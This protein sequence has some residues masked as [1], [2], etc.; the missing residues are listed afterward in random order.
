MQLAF[1]GLGTMGG[2]MAANLLKAGH[3]VTV[4]N[5]TRDKEEPLA[6]KG[7]KRAASPKEAASEAEVVFLCVSDTPDV[8]QVLFGQDGV[9]TGAK[10]GAV[11]ADMSTISPA[12]TRR[13]AAALSEKGIMMVDAPISGGSEGAVNGTL[14]IMVGGEP[15]NV[16]KVEPA[17]E[18]MGRSITHVGPIGAGQMT[19]A[20]NQVILAGY[21][22]ATGEGIALGLKA[23]LDV[24]KVVQAIGGGAAASWVLSNRSNNMIENTYPL[25]FR[26]RLHHKDLRIALE[27]AAELNISLPVAGIVAQYENGLLANGYGDEDVSALARVVRES[28]GLK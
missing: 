14:A 22:L 28:A 20:I 6:A 7:A 4:H 10:P 16:E 25:G 26:V 2:P 23:G 21:Y 24:K 13:F 1:I 12:A 19:K 9:A 15:A 3:Q 17:L 11:V 18:A 5:R 8:E 27:T